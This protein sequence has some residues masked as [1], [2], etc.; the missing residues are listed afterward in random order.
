MS[1]G[2][3]ARG[4]LSSTA[5]EFYSGLL[6]PAEVA[7]I[8]PDS[9]LFYYGNIHSQAG[10]DGILAE[11][12]RRL[13]IS[14]GTFV[15]FGAWDGIY[16]SNCR[17]LYEKGWDGV[18]IE[19]DFAKYQTLCSNYGEKVVCINA[20][21]GME[22]G[23]RLADL[24]QQSGV[25][26]D[27]VTFVSIDVDGP[28]LEIFANLGFAPPVIL[29][30]GGF[31]FSPHLEERIPNDVAAQNIQQPLA[32][33]HATAASLGYVPVCFYQDSYLVRRDLASVF[34]TKNT[35]DLFRDAFC[36]MPIGFR[37]WLL[38]MR[39]NSSV[40]RDY[41]S[42]FFGNFSADPL[43]YRSAGRK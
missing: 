17:L 42:R 38:N 32:V 34:G 3:P 24:L 29:I 19:A 12:F 10:Q 22:Q 1:P 40:V 7:R 37:R 39:A 9:L 6:D 14:S 16:L 20:M 43:A 30:E 21:V 33:I 2:E 31:N 25:A 11:I 4:E 5:G 13:R 26:P 36:F 35:A 8:D 18:F 23:D 41:E 27:S 28:D 15:E